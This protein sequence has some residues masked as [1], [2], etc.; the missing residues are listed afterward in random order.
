MSV[1]ETIKKIVMKIV[2]KPDI[3]FTPTNRNRILRS[4]AIMIDSTNEVFRVAD[5][6]L[7]EVDKRI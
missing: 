1:E 3:D 4:K 7:S 5:L 2:R 6:F